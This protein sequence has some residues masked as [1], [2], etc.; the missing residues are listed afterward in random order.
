MHRAAAA[1]VGMGNGKDTTGYID[2]APIA[3]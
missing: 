2:H 3:V 1:E